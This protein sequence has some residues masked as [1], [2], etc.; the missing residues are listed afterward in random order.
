MSY[1]SLCKVANP[2]PVINGSRQTTIAMHMAVCIL[3]HAKNIFHNVRNLI[4]WNLFVL[5][6]I[7]SNQLYGNT[8]TYM[9]APSSEA[10]SSTCLSVE[11]NLASLLTSILDCG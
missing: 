6:E 10:R 7:S 5:Y 2:Y 8:N 11:Q 3:Y 9:Y 4:L 1:Y